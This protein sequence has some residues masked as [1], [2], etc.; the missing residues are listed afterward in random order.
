MKHSFLL[1]VIV[2]HFAFGQ[3]SL[4]SKMQK[5]HLNSSDLIIQIDKSDRKMTIVADT[6]ELAVYDCVLG[7]NPID[8]K[9]QE[10]DGCTPEGIFKIRSMYPHK[11][12]DYFIWIDYP[13]QESWKKFNQRRREGIIGANASIGGEIGIHGVPENSDS[14]IDNKVDWTLGCI[15]LRESDIKEL[16]LAISKETIIQIQP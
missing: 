9:K 16:Y 13:N 3:E 14:L 11:S 4:K 1:I 5:H 6:L 10:G 2:S 8:D 15:S 12:W 7:F